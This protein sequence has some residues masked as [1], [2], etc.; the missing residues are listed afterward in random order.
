MIILGFDPGSNIMGYSA[1]ETKNDDVN[2]IALG[3]IDVKKQLDLKKRIRLISDKISLVFKMYKPDV[4]SIED[5]FYGKNAQSMLKL[6]RIQGIIINNALMNNIDY[7]FYSPREVKKSVTSL[8][9]SSKKQVQVILEN[10]FETSFNK[11]SFDASDSLA[12]AYCHFVS[13]DK[14]TFVRSK[15][16]KISWSDYIKK[17]NKNE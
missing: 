8:G 4:V 5:S 3:C 1:I 11:Y 2:L 10:I 13:K 17:I 7:F 14:I 6:G 16:L 12:V 15:K 9:T